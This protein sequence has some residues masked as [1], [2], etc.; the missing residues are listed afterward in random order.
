MLRNLMTLRALRILLGHV[1]PVASTQTSPHPAHGPRT[2]F[3][4]SP[5]LFVPNPSDITRVTCSVL[6]LLLL[7]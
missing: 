3:Q 4:L 2:T 5:W 6:S 1:V 7:R